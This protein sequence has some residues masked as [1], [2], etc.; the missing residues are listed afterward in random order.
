MNNPSFPSSPMLIPSTAC[1]LRFVSTDDSIGNNIEVTYDLAKSLRLT[2]ITSCVPD[3]FCPAELTFI[4]LALLLSSARF[5]APKY[6]SPDFKPPTSVSTVSLA[7]PA[8]SLRA[9]IPSA[10]VLTAR[11][12]FL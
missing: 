4:N 12:S 1:K 6:P 11:S 2:S 9:S 5:F 8:T 3:S 10:V 7:E